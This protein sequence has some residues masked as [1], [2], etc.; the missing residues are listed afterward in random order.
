MTKTQFWFKKAQEE[1]FA[2]GAFNAASIET[3]KAIVGAAK[4]LKSP[5]MIEASQGE[6]NYF[7]ARELVG[8]VRAMEQSYEVPIL[9]NLDHA[10]GFD[11]CKVAVD[12]G[13]DYVHLDG[14][15]LD[16]SEN[17]RQTRQLTEYAHKKGVLVEG[18][19]DNINV[20]GA[21]SADHRHESPDA[22]RD[23]KFYTEPEKAY[24]FVQ[25]TGVDTFASFVGNVHGLYQGAKRIDLSRLLRI[26]EK[27]GDRFLSLHGG[28]GIPEQ[29]VDEAIKTGVVKVNVNSELRV[30]FIDK[31]REVLM[32]R[33]PVSA[34]GSGTAAEIAIY[35]L[36]PEAICAMQ[37]I[38]EEKIRLFGSEGKLDGNLQTF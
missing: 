16:L 1:K 13:F 10:A 33:N 22:V 4:N 24:K 20:M 31:L 2:I 3:L 15:K 8:V 11:D 23:E 25:E 38:V 21:S 18:E 6:V 17:I 19:I 9:L 36:M 34:E 7:G 29:D 5:V 37:R 30:A 26:K 35:K 32:E 12:L 28:S 14:S 27:L